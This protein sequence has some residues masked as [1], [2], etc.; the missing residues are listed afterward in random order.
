MKGS[1]LTIHYSFIH[2]AVCL[3]TGPQTLPKRVLHRLRSS[4]SSFNLKCLLFSLRPSSSCLHHLSRL[5][6]TST[7][8]SIFLRYDIGSVVLDTEDCLHDSN[9]NG[10]R[11]EIPLLIW[12][13]CSWFRAAQVYINKCPKRC[14]NMQSIFYFTARSLYVFRV[15][16]APIIR[17]T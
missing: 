8:P 13:L 17:S 9:A 14:N 10:S 16:S 12:N 1:G 4:A 3:T 5:Y 7:L 2:S 15:P 6:V 11:Y